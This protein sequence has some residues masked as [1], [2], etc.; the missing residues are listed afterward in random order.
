MAA[1]MRLAAYSA[2]A[3]ASLWSS[4]CVI[5]LGAGEDGDCSLEPCSSDD[6]DSEP[7]GDSVPTPLFEQ[8]PPGSDPILDRIHGLLNRMAGYELEVWWPQ[9]GYDG[10]GDRFAIETSDEAAVRPITA[11]ALGLAVTLSTGAY[12]ATAVGVAESE[13][14][15]IT[16]RLITSLA[17]AHRVNGGGWGDTWQSALWASSTGLAAWLLWDELDAEVRTMVTRV[18]VHEADNFRDYQVPYHRDPMGR[19]ISPGDTKAEENSWNSRVLSLAL[20]MYPN[21]P[22]AAGWRQKK[23][24]LQISSYANEADV[25]DDTV[26]HGVPLCRWLGGFNA[27]AN[28]YLVNHRRLHPGYMRTPHHAADAVHALIADLPVD[29]AALLNLDRT[30]AAL[31]DV[32]FDS[33]PQLAPGGAAYRA[34]TSD[35]YF[36]HGDDW[37]GNGYVQFAAHDVQ[38]DALGFDSAAS[39]PAADWIDLRWMRVE[40]QMD[41]FNDGQVY[42]EGEARSPMAEQDAFEKSADAYL[43]RFLILQRE[44]RITDDNYGVSA[45]TSCPARDTTLSYCPS[46][47]VRRSHMAAFLMRLRHGGEFVARP[48]EGM[49]ADVPLKSLFAG[50]IEQLAREG[51]TAGCRVGEYCP[52]DVVRRDQMATFLVRYLYGASYTPPPAQGIFDDVPASSTHA[53]SIEQLYRDGIING[54]TASS[55]CPAESLSRAQ[56]ATLLVRASRGASYQAPAARG[57]FADV[58]TSNI[59]ARNIEYIYDRGITLGCQ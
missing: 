31:V 37:G 45:P 57:V 58:D 20:A 46:E 56:M 53:R 28:G 21:H 55:Y 3:V 32:S 22:S 33:P 47:P 52:S 43:T 48:A 11:V 25:F 26:I 42:A 19:V 44:L 18:I 14:L 17:A 29:R 7:D 36:P 2:I 51:V 8:I 16:Q 5:D 41:R 40:Q 1:A 13:A 9:S 59:H 50:E 4:A 30:Y 35:L 15:R 39:R 54:C 38:A 6:D 27:M 49:F 34:G 24:E 12:D 23:I 10:A